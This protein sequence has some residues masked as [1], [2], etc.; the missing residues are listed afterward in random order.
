MKKADLIVG[1]LYETK[2][3][4]VK[5]TNIDIKQTRKKVLVDGRN[6]FKTSQIASYEVQSIGTG[7]KMTFATPA[8]FLSVFSQKKAAKTLLKPSPKKPVVVDTDYFR[9]TD[10]SSG[11]AGR[12]KAATKGKVKAPHLIVQAL[13]GTGKTTTLIEGLKQLK[14]E[15]SNLSPSPQQKAIWDSMLL[16]SDARSICFVAFNKSIAEELKRRVPFGCQASTMHSM[17]NSAIFKTFGRLEV[18]SYRVSNIISEILEMDVREIRKHKPTV[19][20]ATEQLVGYCKQNLIGIGE[21]FTKSDPKKPNPDWDEQ[22]DDNWQSALES[23]ASYYEVDLNDS[24]QEVF[25]LVP[26]VLERCRDVGKDR[27]IDFNDMIWLPIVLDLSMTKYDLLLVDEAQD[28]NRCQQALAKK[29]GDRLILVGDKHQAIYGF[30]GADSESMDR[31]EIE[32]SRVTSVE[33]ELGHSA[34]GCIV[35]PLTVTRRCGEAI[36]VEARKIVHAFQAH[37]NNGPGLVRNLPFAGE[38]NY[39]AEV[40]DGDMILCR[41]NAPLVLQCFRFIKDGRKAVIQGRDIGQGLVKTIR[42]IGGDTVLELVERLDDWY[43]K[44]C[45]KEASKKFPSEAHLINLQDRY[46]CMMCFTEGATTIE[47][48]IEKIESIFTDNKDSVGIKLSS[49]HRAK[50]LESRRVYIIQPPGASMSHPMAKVEW[51]K[52][53]EMNI[54]YVAITRAIEE[55]IWVN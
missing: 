45:Q 34:R 24:A 4:I 14:G 29:A 12:L 2:V 8:R 32:L 1:Q 50:G 39:T 43:H 9:P 54:K 46:E 11:L 18:Q 30:A 19:L 21:N 3:G 49:V 35:L 33:G 27:T 31:M 28:L 15:T 42:K 23:L 25:D 47:K 17:G 36:A 16:S 52:K 40:R 53:Q 6:K 13:A 44:E 7:R 10:K 55:L 38:K 22:V 48:V 51:Q 5:L 26:Q 41:V 37:P 20:S